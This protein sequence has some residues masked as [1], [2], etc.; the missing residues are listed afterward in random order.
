MKRT[1]WL[2]AVVIVLLLAPMF[3][4]RSPVSDRL[5][6]GAVG[7]DRSDD[8]WMVSAQ[9]LTDEQTV[10][11]LSGQTVADAMSDAVKITGRD[12]ELRQNTLLCMGENT[13][14]QYRL[15]AVTDY[16]LRTGNGRLTTDVMI[17][18]G[19]ADELLETVPTKQLSELADRAEVFAK[20]VRSRLLDI[21]R[22]LSDGG[23]AVVPI[24]RVEEERGVMDG[25]A[26]YVGDHWMTELS[27]EQTV[28]LIVL[29]D[30]AEVCTVTV[31]SCTVEL[32]ELIRRITV[33][34]H[35]NR[36]VIS[37]RLTAT[38][39]VQ[40]QIGGVAD[41]AMVENTI[42]RYVTEALRITAQSYGSDVCG[43]WD[44]I[45]KQ[46][47]HTTSLSESERKQ[48]LQNSDYDV[49]VS[50]NITETGSR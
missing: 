32:T 26:L 24:I 15:S 50:V 3:R 7:I 5:I 10:I 9:L 48:H 17:V 30:A 44:S 23:D 20:G 1:V 18:R 12:L 45:K 31:G 22:T 43:L 37:V 27:A 46:M 11:R 42:G 4:R 29:Q 6:V 19:T 41:A 35:G 8:T 2:L 21:C 13:A 33:K 49:R 14:R 39:A 38:G 36:W 40:E 47:P 16:L 25:A 34:S 28:G